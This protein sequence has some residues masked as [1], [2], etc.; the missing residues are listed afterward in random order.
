MSVWT[1]FQILGNVW[2]SSSSY[3]LPLCPPKKTKGA[4]CW[5]HQTR[6]CHICEMCP[7]S[8]RHCAILQKQFSHRCT[9]R[10]TSG[11]SHTIVQITLAPRSAD[12]QCANYTILENVIAPSKKSHPRMHQPVYW[13]PR[14]SAIARTTLRPGPLAGNKWSGLM[15]SPIAGTLLPHDTP[16]RGSQNYESQEEL[17]KKGTAYCRSRAMWV[18]LRDGKDTKRNRDIRVA[19]PSFLKEDSD[20]AIP[21]E[22][23]V[24]I[25]RI[26]RIHHGSSGPGASA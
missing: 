9:V 20:A 6:T 4:L 15:P 5:T 7:F 1:L 10:I 14:K 22:S 21:R 3:R 16:S 2:P 17:C 23:H 12:L 25:R 26:A 18:Q 8:P 19:T 13:S 11:S 24:G